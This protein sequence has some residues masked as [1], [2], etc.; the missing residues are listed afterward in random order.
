MCVYETLK[1]IT[2]VYDCNW[3][4]REDIHIFFYLSQ[5][6][7]NIWKWSTSQRPLWLECFFGK[8][9]GSA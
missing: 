4:P 7:D 5:H 2:G 6:E 8:A 1:I 3:L 9:G